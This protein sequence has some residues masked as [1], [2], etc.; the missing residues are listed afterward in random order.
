M[1]SIKITHTKDFMNKLLL[2]EAFDA[3][4]VKEASISTFFTLQ[5]EGKRIK[6]FYSSEELEAL[7]EDHDFARWLEI[8]PFCLQVIRG[9]KTPVSFKF[10]FKL[11]SKNTSKFL[12][13]TGLQISVADV[14]GLFL[15]IHFE[16]GSI[17][18]TSGTSLKIFTM[19]KSLDKEWD[20]MVER[21]L[22]QQQLDY[23]IL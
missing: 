19:D 2:S 4:L 16:Q 6:D 8:K 3:F 15:H 7:G 1:I 21:F 17:T 20:I 5:L 9:K 23:E 12:Q 13:Q 18:C 14:S 22:K 11:S 10:V